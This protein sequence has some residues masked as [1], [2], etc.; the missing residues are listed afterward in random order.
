M[1]V[2]VKLDHSLVGLCMHA[3]VCVCV[4]VFVCVCVVCV[5]VCVCIPT[6]KDINCYYHEAKTW[7]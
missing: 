6:L 4:C 1:I 2:V 3:R 5:Y 7:Q